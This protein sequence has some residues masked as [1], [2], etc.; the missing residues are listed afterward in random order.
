MVGGNPL[1]LKAL[2][3]EQQ[4]VRK[5]GP[6]GFRMD[7]AGQGG[8]RRRGQPGRH[9]PLPLGPE[10]PETREVIE[11]LSCAR[12]VELSRLTE[13]YGAGI[14]ADMEDA[15]LL[16]IDG[17]GQPLGFP[18][19]K[20]PWR[21]RPLLAEH[22]PAA[23]TPEP[24]PGRQGTG[25]CHHDRGRADGI[26][27]LD[28]R[29]RGR[30]QPGHGAGRGRG[31]R[32]AVRPAFCPQLRREPEEERR[33][34]GSPGSGRKPPHTCCWTCRCRPWPPSTTFPSRSWTTLD[35]EEFAQVVAAKC[36]GHG[37]AAGTTRTGCRRMLEKAR[38][39][40]GVG[41]E[42]GEGLA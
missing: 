23:G 41:P 19:G 17:L 6:V 25:P 24:A 27:R 4:H 40:L 35:V 29:M 1:L 31:S 13:I 16:D 28:A 5:P 30:T 20:V 33:A 26:R 39:R 18:A 38:A 21:R 2:V 42:H 9:R 22:L 8:A 3:T 32:A 34:M 36:T 12:S 37:L 15:G 14:V 7:S 11:M 10:T